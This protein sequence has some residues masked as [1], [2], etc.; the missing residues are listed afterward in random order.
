MDYRR[1]RLDAGIHDG[2]LVKQSYKKPWAW[3]LVKKSARFILKRK[4]RV[5]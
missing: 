5:C 3:V 4:G 2:K 1:V